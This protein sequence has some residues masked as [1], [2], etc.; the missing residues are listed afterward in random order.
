MF[1]IQQKRSSSH[2][3]RVGVFSSAGGY[4]INHVLVFAADIPYLGNFVGSLP[5]VRPLSLNT[6]IL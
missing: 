3:A 2:F 5:P 4:E 1:Q 6:L